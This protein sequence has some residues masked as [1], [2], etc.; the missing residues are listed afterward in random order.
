MFDDLNDLYQQVI[1]D[2]SKSPRNFRKILDANFEGQGRN[3]LC[4][5]QVKVYLKLEGDT[6]KG[7]SEFP[8]FNGGEPTKR[9]WEAKRAK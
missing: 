2:H 5:D 9:D 4:G 3:P 8:G 1:L 6:I 7:S